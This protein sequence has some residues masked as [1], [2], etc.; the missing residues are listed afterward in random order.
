MGP[1]GKVRERKSVRYKHT[2]SSHLTVSKTLFQML[3][4]LLV[5]TEGAIVILSIADNKFGKVWPAETGL[6]HTW[7][8]Q[9]W[10]QS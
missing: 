10:L 3:P 4:P 5:T 8:S 7:A 6:C 9:P 1:E 2:F